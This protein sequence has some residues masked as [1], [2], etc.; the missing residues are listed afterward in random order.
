MTWLG[1]D[2]AGGG[3]GGSR[4]APRGWTSP[5]TSGAGTNSLMDAVASRSSALILDGPEPDEPDDP[6]SDDPDGGHGVRGPG[7]NPPTTWVTYG[8][9]NGRPL[10]FKPAMTPASFESRS[11]GGAYA[12]NSPP[13]V[14]GSAGLSPTRYLS[15][16]GSRGVSP[17]APDKLRY[18]VGQT[19]PS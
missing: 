1:T 8:Y 5:G 3:D 19:S 15:M 7:G 14:D 13:K 11:L 10:R 2:G 12:L 9:G 18:T 6:D 16:F 4:T 17:Q